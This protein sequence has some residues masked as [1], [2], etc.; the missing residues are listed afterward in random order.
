M[1][2]SELSLILVYVCVLVIKT[3]GM[4]PA[5]CATFGFGEDAKGEV[6]PACDCALPGA[7]AALSLC[8]SG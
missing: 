6:E 7:N 3:C 5:V 4:S 2:L 8:R 1:T